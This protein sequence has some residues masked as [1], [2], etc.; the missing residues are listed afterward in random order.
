MIQE[1][2]PARDLEG[3]STDELRTLAA[4]FRNQVE[5]LTPIVRLNAREL[6]LANLGLKRTE[7]ALKGKTA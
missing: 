7:A 3:L 6:A 2:Y 1:H 5:H 4:G